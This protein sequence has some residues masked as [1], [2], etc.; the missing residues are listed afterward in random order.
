MNIQTVIANLLNT[1][2]E[3]KQVLKQLKRDAFRE[4]GSEYDV[5]SALIIG[6]E[7]HL[8]QLNAILNDCMAVREADIVRDLEIKELKRQNSDYSWQVSPDR[9]GQ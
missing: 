2:D 7:I 6:I 4:K 9:M 8:K 3:R 1:I 5:T